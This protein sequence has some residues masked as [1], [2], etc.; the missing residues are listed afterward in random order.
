MTPQL[1]KEVMRSAR[2]QEQF[3]CLEPLCGDTTLL[4]NRSSLHVSGK[5]R[6]HAGQTF[7]IAQLKKEVMRS[8]RYQEQFVFLRENGLSTQED[9]AA[10]QTRTASIW[11]R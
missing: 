8:A 4:Q 6:F 5:L 9:M 7:L 10:F 11:G 1:K 3:V 2:Y